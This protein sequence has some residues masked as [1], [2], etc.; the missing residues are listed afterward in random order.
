MENK[1]VELNITPQS[2]ELMGIIL[3][4][5]QI[6]KEQKF[7]KQSLEKILL[8]GDADSLQDIISQFNAQLKK[9]IREEEWNLRKY[10]YK[11]VAN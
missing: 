10:D 4:V 1:I 3:Q 8:E 6:S 9:Q 7:F 11:S 5:L 2:S